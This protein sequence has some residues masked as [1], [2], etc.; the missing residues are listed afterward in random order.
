MFLNIKQNIKLK[1]NILINQTHICNRKFIKKIQNPPLLI[2][3]YH[4]RLKVHLN[5]PNQIK[6]NI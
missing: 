3:S 1:I 6:Q 4:K 2:I 5:K